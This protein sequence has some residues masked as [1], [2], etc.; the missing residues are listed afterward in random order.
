MFLKQ[1]LK[2]YFPDNACF[3]DVKQAELEIDIVF[4]FLG[5]ERGNAF[6]R[7]FAE[8]IKKKLWRL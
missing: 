7:I 5:V 8:H 3:K 1:S 2:S 4:D 6:I